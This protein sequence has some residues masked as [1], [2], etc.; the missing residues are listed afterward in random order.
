MIELNFEPVNGAWHKLDH[1]E[2]AL[3]VLHL[4]ISTK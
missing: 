4:F 1:R 2:K 3:L